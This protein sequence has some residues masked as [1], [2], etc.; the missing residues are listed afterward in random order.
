MT[1][2][3]GLIGFPLGHSF[4][5]EY[6]D[7]KISS[8]N[9]E[10]IQYS[11]FPL[12]NIE[13]FPLLYENESNLFG[14]NVTIPHKQ[15][16]IPFLD[17]LSREAHEIGAVNCVTIQRDSQNANRPILTGYN[18]DAFGFEQSLTALLRPRHEKALVLGNGG[19]AKA[20]IYVLRKL[21]IHP[22]LVS[23]RKQADTV[24]YG[25][26]DDKLIQEHL[27]IVNCSPLGTFPNI[28]DYPDI[29]YDAL[30][31]D[32]YLY[33]L[34]YNPQETLFLKKGRERGA[35]VKNGYEM[36]TLQAEKNWEIW[37]S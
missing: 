6:Y 18:T 14:V 30:T 17:T 8:G 4:S 7:A 27:L 26:L 19:A 29:P 20:V 5:K 32:H 35:S 13:D 11:L 34:I 10:G 28:E 15:A 22:Q 3:F 9:I 24:T 33:D 37:L 23:R 36:L 1:K 31:A 12:E 25:E 16:I 2:K 21:G